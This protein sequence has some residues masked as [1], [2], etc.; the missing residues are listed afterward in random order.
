[1][2]EQMTHVQYETWYHININTNMKTDTNTDL[3]TSFL[4]FSKAKSYDNCNNNHRD[5]SVLTNK[6]PNIYMYSINCVKV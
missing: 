5:A 4:Y 2:D 1:M 6:C 3:T